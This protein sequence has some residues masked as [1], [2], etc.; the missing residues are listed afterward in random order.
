MKIKRRGVKLRYLHWWLLGVLTLGSAI[1]IGWYWYEQHQRTI[2]IEQKTSQLVAEVDARI[3]EIERKRVEPVYV[4]LPGA[5]TI[6]VIREDF[7]EPSSI[8]VLVN[9]KN[10]IPLDYVPGL[11]SPG[12]PIR[13]GATSDERSVS[14]AIV[15]PLKNLFAAAEKDG[16]LLMIGSAYR[17]SA[18]QTALFNGYVASAGLEQA[19]KYSARPGHSEHQLGL[20]VDISTL[21]QQCYLSAC[22]INTPDGQWLADNAHK[23][24]FFIRYQKGKES[25]TGYNF[26]PWHY[27][28]VGKDLATALYQS[29]LTF[30]EAWP[31][32]E[33]ARQTLIDNRAI[34]P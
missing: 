22:F 8:W 21:S 17:S 29:G 28:Y 4:S 34:A 1:F 33:A 6:E 26:E 7:T 11:A 32:L 13:S 18:V 14:K 30:E 23:Y 15:K 3:A 16:H 5:D 19:S 12:V 27:R 31:Y 24:G 9:K 20:A 25:I 10:S 2:E